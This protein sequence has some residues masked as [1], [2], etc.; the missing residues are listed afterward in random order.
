MAGRERGGASR[1]SPVEAEL[2]RRAAEQDRARTGGGRTLPPLVRE[3]AYVLLTCSFLG[4]WV[5]TGLV[6]LGMWVLGVDHSSRAGGS[7]L[8]V[9]W[10]L[11]W[12][13]LLPATL[14]W[15]A[16]ELLKREVGPRP[17]TAKGFPGHLLRHSDKGVFDG[18]IPLALN[19]T[20][21]PPHFWLAV[22]LFTLFSGYGAMSSSGE[23]AG[24]AWAIPYWAAFGA[25][26]ASLGVLTHGALTRRATRKGAVRQRHERSETT[27]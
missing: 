19:K 10:I 4:F 9:G 15:H 5:W 18:S 21:P 27:R 24:T 14:L 16:P 22:V 7:V 8:L 12:I 23:P 11:C 25:C 3:Y 2:A 6:A 26:V 20:A 13:L 1:L 17:T